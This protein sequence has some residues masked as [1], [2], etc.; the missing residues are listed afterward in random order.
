MET[1]KPRRLL[2]FLGIDW[3]A[4]STAWVAPIWMFAL[5]VVI[6]FVAESHANAGK[7]LLFGLAYG[8]LLFA[9]IL[10]HYLGGAVAGRV[11]DAPMR[12]V[13]FTATLAYNNYD[14]SREFPSRIHLIRGLSEPAANLIL[15]GVML[16]LYLAGNHSHFVL[17]L[18]ILNLAFFIIAM[19]PFPTMHG[20]VLL[21]HLE[22]WRRD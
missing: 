21:K 22:M 2:K 6:G 10:V 4:T 18:A 19:A 5:G 8:A 20:G 15:G 11:V 14:E 7:R 9:S 17:F 13:V 16:S 1:D 3:M 12:R